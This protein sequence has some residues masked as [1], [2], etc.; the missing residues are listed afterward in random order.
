MLFGNIYTNVCFGTV[1]SA[2]RLYCVKFLIWL[3]NREFTWKPA[4]VLRMDFIINAT[5]MHQELLLD[6]EIKAENQ[7]I[8]RV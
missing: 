4:E 1:T 6:P 2:A 7:D 8:Q 5:N 3:Q